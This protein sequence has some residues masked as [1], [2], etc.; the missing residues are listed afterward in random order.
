MHRAANIISDKYNGLFPNSFDNIIQLPGIGR[1]TAGAIGS[2]AFNMVVPVID[3]N[4]LRV[5][6]RIFAVKDDITLTKTKNQFWH[7]AEQLISQKS[8]GDFNQ[9]LM[10]LGATVCLP[11]YPL[12]IDCPLFSVCRANMKN[13][14]TAFPVKKPKSPIPHYHIGAGLIWR[15][16]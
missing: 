6:S 4:V 12:C 9:A 13:C 1:Y 15:N 8:P 5:L 2:I 10:E 11:R 3:G 7:L 14:Q 16:R